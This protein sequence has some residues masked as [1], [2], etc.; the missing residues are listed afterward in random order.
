MSS[1]NLHVIENR[2][3]LGQCPNKGGGKVIFCR[4]NFWW[5]TKIDRKKTC[6]RKKTNFLSK[7]DFGKK[8]FLV[9]NF[10][11]KKIFVVKNF[12]RK[13]FLMEKIFMSKKFLIEKKFWVEPFFGQ[14]EI[15]I[16]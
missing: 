16:E 8:N 14:I 3:N 10:C 4:T 12:W 11:Q 2:K 9:Q 13:N 7:K 1:G 5:K 15:L 6:G